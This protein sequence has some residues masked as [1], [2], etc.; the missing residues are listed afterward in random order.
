MPEKKEMEVCEEE[1][2]WRTEGGRK[3]VGLARAVERVEW[4]RSHLSERETDRG[5]REGDAERWKKWEGETDW[6]RETE[7]EAVGSF[8]CG[9]EELFLW[10]KTSLLFLSVLSSPFILLWLNICLSQLISVSSSTVLVSSPSFCGLSV[11]LFMIYFVFLSLCLKFFFA[12]IHLSLIL[13]VPIAPL[14]SMASTLCFPPSIFF[15]FYSPRMHL[16][17]ACFTNTVLKARELESCLGV[18]GANVD[19][20]L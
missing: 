9:S 15:S 5:E 8:L 2:E 13:S 20:V 14:F 18:G 6:G 11:L 4:T 10:K 7:S 1:Q 16:F 17:K 3:E 19:R 12:C